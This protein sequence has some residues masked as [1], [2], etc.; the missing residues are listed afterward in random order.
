MSLKTDVLKDTLRRIFTEQ[1]KQEDYVKYDPDKDSTT[2]DGDAFAGAKEK[3]ES[4]ADQIA[5]AIDEFVRSGTV[6]VVIKTGKVT[7]G[8]GATSAPNVAPIPVTGDPDAVSLLKGG[9]T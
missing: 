5:G 4:I 1:I 2:L 8:A 7:Q 6:K 9:I 3:G